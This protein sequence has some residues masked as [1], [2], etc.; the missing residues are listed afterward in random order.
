VCL[1]YRRILSSWTGQISYDT[2]IAKKNPHEGDAM[3]SA[4]GMASY[5]G[6]EQKIVNKEQ[7]DISRDKVPGDWP[8]IKG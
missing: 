8:E 5:R 3:S 2:R 1:L 6:S 7:K 4:F